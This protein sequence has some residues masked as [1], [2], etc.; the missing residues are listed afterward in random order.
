MIRPGRDRAVTEDVRV[1]E[2]AAGA[3]DAAEAGSAFRHPREEIIDLTGLAHVGMGGVHGAKGAHGR[4]TARGEAV[5]V[6]EDVC[7]AGLVELEPSVERPALGHDELLLDSCLA[8]G[9]GGLVFGA[10]AVFLDRAQVLGKL[11]AEVAV[12]MRAVGAGGGAREEDQ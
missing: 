1:D 7:D 10:V 4:A 5:D 8:V 12:W 9:D 6:G 3:L 2:V 11:M